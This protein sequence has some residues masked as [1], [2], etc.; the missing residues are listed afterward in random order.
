MSIF[1]GAGVAMITPFHS[2]RI[3]LLIMISWK[4][5]LIF[6]SI[7]E[8]TASLSAEPQEKHPR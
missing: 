3:Y 4:N 1:T 8:P 5:L 6:R 2:K 7:T